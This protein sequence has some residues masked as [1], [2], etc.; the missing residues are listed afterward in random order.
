M[1]VYCPEDVLLIESN[2]IFLSTTTYH[3]QHFDYNE[4]VPL[5]FKSSLYIAAWYGANFVQTAHIK[6]RYLIG[7]NLI[8]ERLHYLE[9]SKRDSTFALYELTMQ[10]IWQSI[11]LLCKSLF[12][13]DNDKT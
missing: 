13:V 8:K 4:N 11:Q 9:Q 3:W 7:Q 1:S 12:D 6:S 2:S 10:Q 5:I